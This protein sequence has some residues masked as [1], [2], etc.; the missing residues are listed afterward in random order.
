MENFIRLIRSLKL[1]AMSPEVQISYLKKLGTYPSCDELA[2]EFDDS[3]SPSKPP[4]LGRI[5]EL[6]AL[7]E[8]LVS[9]DN[10]LDSMSNSDD[11]GLWNVESLA[12][13]KWMKVRNL[14]Q[15]AILLIEERSNPSLA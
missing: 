4:L 5:G 7:E 6:S 8:T 11:E 13:T 10:E 1:L 3:F 14:A 9:I 15:R 12:G 2:L